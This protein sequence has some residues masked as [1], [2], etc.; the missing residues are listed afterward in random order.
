VPPLAAR[1]RKFLR[2]LAEWDCFGRCLGFSAWFSAILICLSIHMPEIIEFKFA[3]NEDLF[4]ANSAV[5]KL[6]FSAM[7]LIFQQKER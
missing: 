2:P 7:L 6:L 3:A 4:T 1:G 5:N